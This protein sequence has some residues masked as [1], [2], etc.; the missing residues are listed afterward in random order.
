MHKTLFITLTLMAGLMAGC[1][2]IPRSVTPV[3]DTKFGEALRSA[4]LKQTLNPNAGAIPDPVAGMDGMAARE[5]ILRYQ[6][7]FKEPPPVANVINI[8]GGLR[9]K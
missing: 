7:G 1:A 5:T 2:P 6:E 9:T 4:L 3:Y 8:G